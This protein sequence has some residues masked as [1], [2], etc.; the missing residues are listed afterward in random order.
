M[1]KVDMAD[2]SRSG[3]A[4]G[5][6]QKRRTVLVVG[7][8]GRLGVA[9]AAALVKRQSRVVLTA[10]DPDK[11]ASMAHELG[12]PENSEPA[13]V[14]ADLT[15]E[16]AA[17]LIVAGVRNTV[18]RIDDIVLACGP[19][20]RTPFETLRRE[21][22]HHT[23]TVHAVAPLLLVHALA[24]DLAAA[25]GAVVALGDVGTSRPYT[26][27]VAYITAKGALKAG[28][29]AL[30]AELAPDVRIN[31][32]Q[33]GIVADPEADLDPLR[34]HRLAARSSLGRF[35]TP[36]EVAHVVLALLDAT[37]TTGETWNI[38]R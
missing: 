32:L 37:W 2:N 38:G 24:G 15:R 9:I 18:G 23:L 3:T 5:E 31:M 20:P 22:L 34:T 29:R 35:G 6:P 25:Q 30:S 33:L 8:T 21:D 27:H 12:G 36:E 19:F 13:V 1:G 17:S 28:L 4:H 10:R 11:L 14:C 26:N 16:D 7:A